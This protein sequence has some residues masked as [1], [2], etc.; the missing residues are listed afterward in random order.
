MSNVVTDDYGKKFQLT[1]SLL[2]RILRQED[3][4]SI[5]TIQPVIIVSDES[6]SKQLSN[7]GYKHVAISSHFLYVVNTPAKQESDLLLSVPLENV[8]SVQMV[9]IKF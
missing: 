3:Y 2:K 1:D 7:P 5:K 4:D 9:R 8:E 6:S